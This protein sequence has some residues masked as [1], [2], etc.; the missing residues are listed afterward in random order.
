MAIQRKS[1]QKF[2]FDRSFDDPNMLYLPGEKRKAER[3]AA[4]AAAAIAAAEAAQNATL[5]AGAMPVE[6][7]APPA[8]PAPKFSQGDL[9]AAR[10][11]G[12]V[13]GHAAALEEISTSREQY[14]ADALTLVG[15]GL[16]KLDE[17]Q[18]VAN[19]EMGE[20]VMRLVYAL[21]RKVIPIE[22]EKHAIE[23]ISQFV[24]KVLPLVIGEPK[25]IVRV[26]SSIVPLV[27]ERLKTTFTRASFQGG[28]SV[29]ADFELQPGDCRLDWSGGGADRSEARIWA[30]IREVI[31]ANYGDVDI[32]ALDRLADPEAAKIKLEHEQENGGQTH[33]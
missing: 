26:H 3:E 9:D 1:L 17:K 16:G 33:G 6:E 21:M 24:S 13:A 18:A 31:A 2:M 25:L 27:E 29:I 12:Y 23:N 10:E 11:D 22:A 5:A 8:P 32:D 14:V 15:Q 30:E 28:F 4:E 7:D 20:T 19:R